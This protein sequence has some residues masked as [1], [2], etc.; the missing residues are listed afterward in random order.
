MNSP[1]YTKSSPLLRDG[2]VVST[3]FAQEPPL[4]GFRV[5]PTKITKISHD[6]PFRS[7]V[8]VYQLTL[9]EIG[10]ETSAPMAVF[11]KSSKKDDFT[12]LCA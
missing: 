3:I 4:G 9:P 7:P 10:N 2:F 12:R 8:Q 6:A 11:F 1:L 5:S